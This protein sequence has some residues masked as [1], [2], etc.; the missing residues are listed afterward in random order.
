MRFQV[1]MAVIGLLAAV[2]HADAIRYD[3][4]PADAV[5]YFHGDLDRLLATRLSQIELNGGVSLRKNIEM[6]GFQHSVW[7]SIKSATMFI[8]G[9]DGDPVLLLRGSAKKFQQEVENPRSSDVVVFDYDH[10]DVHYSSSCIL[11]E[12]FGKG[13]H[14]ENSNN[15]IQPQINVGLGIE[16]SHSRFHGA[17]YTAYIGQDLIVTALEL[18]AM[19]EALD[20]I[21]GKKPSLAQENPHDLRVEA[22]RGVFFIGTGLSAEWVGGNIGIG[23][24]L[25]EDKSTT[26]PMRVA[27]SDFGMDL[28]GS[29]KGKARI[30]RFDMG[31]D[32]Q[33]EYADA[34]FTMI[35]ADSAG[36]L[37]NLLLGVKA[38]VSLSQAQA[39]P[40]IDPLEIDTA[41]NNVT[42]HW[43]MSTAKLSELIRQMAEAPNHDSSLPT[44]VSTSQTAH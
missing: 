17:F 25:P 11:P 6:P 18:P 14:A 9:K 38:L 2:G 16:G 31:E 27:N 5:G 30:A 10:Q 43:S 26:R 34:S 7:G 37:K 12:V 15:D 19:A 3:Q 42:L 41:A 28:F 32:E 29:F 4:I 39:T 13:G 35:D 23:G 21:N 1:I 22:P 44:N 36:Q 24:K 20:V 8:L 40:L 33:N